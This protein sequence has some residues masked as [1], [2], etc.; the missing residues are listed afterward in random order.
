M[1]L[2]LDQLKKF[3]DTKGFTPL[4]LNESNVNA[5]YE[6]CFPPS[7]PRIIQPMTSG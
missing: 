2:T 5:I 3:K 6:R 4:E 7:L 1:G